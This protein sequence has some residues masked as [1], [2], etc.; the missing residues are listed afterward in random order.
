MNIVLAYQPMAVR[1]IQG[2]Y[3][4][5]VDRLT[6]RLSPSRRILLPALAPID[7]VFTNVDDHRGYMTYR[8][9]FVV[10]VGC[11]HWII[12]PGVA[13][14]WPAGKIVAELAIVPVPILDKLAM[15]VA[16]A[17]VFYAYL[18]HVHDLSHSL[19]I[20]WQND[21]IALNPDASGLQRSLTIRMPHQLTAYR[22]L[23]QWPYAQP[24][25]DGDCQT[26]YD[27]IDPIASM[28][29]RALCATQR[30]HQRVG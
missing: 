20:G 4:A 3:C 14:A 28:V 21:R 19:V 15:T 18:A 1:V 5:L 2:V 10:R 8:E 12:A 24:E 9:I 13:D 27:L 7:R 29:T 16:N 25:A 17:S 26:T 30:A 11:Q 6:D 23:D 22:W